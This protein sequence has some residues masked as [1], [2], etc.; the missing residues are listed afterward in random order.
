MEPTRTG[1]LGKAPPPA[2]PGA[3]FTTGSPA[4]PI[5]PAAAAQRPTPQPAIDPQAGAGATFQGPGANGA[6][7]GPLWRYAPASGQPGGSLELSMLDGLLAVTITP[8]NGKP[9]AVRLPAAA[10]LEMRVA[11]ARVDL[12]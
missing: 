2:E 5:E 1:E 3:Q 4:G 10:S 7:N 11:L 8:D 9:A 6:R 12:R